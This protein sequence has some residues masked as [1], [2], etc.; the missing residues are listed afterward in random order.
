MLLPTHETIR[1][2]SRRIDPQARA[3]DLRRYPITNTY[4]A[5][6]LGGWLS[7]ERTSGNGP[8]STANFALTLAGSMG[9]STW[10]NATAGN[11]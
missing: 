5:H 3:V 9:Q 1:S 7:S 2:S 6:A 11:G 4:L 10:A 8:S